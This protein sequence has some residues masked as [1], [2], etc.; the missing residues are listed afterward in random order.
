MQSLKYQAQFFLSNI[1][2]GIY[3]Y[4]NK[5]QNYALRIKWQQYERALSVEN[6]FIREPNVWIYLANIYVYFPFW[7]ASEYVEVCDL[8]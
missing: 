4:L 3:F 2:N 1:K 7:S 5:K 8:V 6:T